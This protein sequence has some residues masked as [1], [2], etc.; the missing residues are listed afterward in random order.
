LNRT[1][2]KTFQYLLIDFLYWLNWEYDQLNAK[3]HTLIYVLSFLSTKWSSALT[4]PRSI[5]WFWNRSKLHL[6]FNFFFSNSGCCLTKLNLV[7]ILYIT[8][9]Q[10]DVHEKT[11]QRKR[12]RFI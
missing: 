8:E 2:T 10:S 4:I 12:E 1:Q 3:N 11:S 5:K 7:T 9:N 6:L